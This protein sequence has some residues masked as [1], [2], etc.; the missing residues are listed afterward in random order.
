MEKKA[1]RMDIPFG[2]DNAISREKLRRLWNCNDREARLIIANLR[3][4]PGEDGCA[5]LSTSSTHP[6]GYWRSDNPAEI[7]AFIKET[8]GRARS[9][10]LSLKDARRVLRNCGR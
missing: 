1:N 9:T 5:I 3:R 6:A 2:R 4:Y 7:S 8:E 10:F